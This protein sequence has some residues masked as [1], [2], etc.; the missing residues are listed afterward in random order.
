MPKKK[1]SDVTSQEIKQDELLLEVAKGLKSL[2]DKVNGIEEQLA[3]KDDTEKKPAEKTV[4]SSV[5]VTQE[6]RTLIDN[7]LNKEFKAELGRSDNPAFLAFRIFVPRKYSNASQAHWDLYDSDERVKNII[8]A[9]ALK[10]IQSYL[11]LV[12]KN[13]NPDVQARI[14]LDR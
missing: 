5:G 8:P 9:E 4:D 10:E 3:K 13:F 6:I 7:V 1:T 12:F 2:T 11:D 14:A